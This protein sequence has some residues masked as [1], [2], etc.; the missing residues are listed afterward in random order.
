MYSHLPRQSTRVLPRP[1]E[2][3]FFRSEKPRKPPRGVPQPFAGQVWCVTG[4]FERFQPREKAMEEVTKRGGR[5]VSS[6]SAKTTHLL[7]GDGA[8]SKLAKA[9]TLGVTV[10]SE[11]DFLRLIGSS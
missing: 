8:G 1:S 2:R 7:A 6:V 3:K 4:S 11:A 5:V 9:R 10:V